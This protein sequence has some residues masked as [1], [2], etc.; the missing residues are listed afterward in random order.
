MRGSGETRPK[1][2]SKM[3]YAKLLNK[4]VST[5]LPRN[6][7]CMSSGVKLSIAASSELIV[8]LIILAFFSCSNTMRLS[9]ESSMQS[10]VIEHGR[11]WPMRWQRSADCHSAAGF[12][13]LSQISAF[14]SRL[15]VISTLNLRVNNEHVRSL[16][17]IKSNT[18]SFE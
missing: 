11:L 7:N 8:E 4:S 9:T 16:G 18:S 15:R 5:Q 10:R 6:R 13:H 12:H 14:V 17:Q 2:A 1:R 3:I